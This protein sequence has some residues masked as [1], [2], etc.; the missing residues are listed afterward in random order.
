MTSFR[1]IPLSEL[2][3]ERRESPD[4][5][6][7]LRGDIP[8][9][10]KVT[11]A[12]GRIHLRTENDSS[13]N[14]IL[15]YP[16]DLL[17]SGINAAKGAIA[18]NEYEHLIAA[19]IHYSAYSINR[20][21]VEPRYLWWFL[22]SDAF[23][24]II[25]K[26]IPGGIKSELRAKRLLPLRVPV[27]S[28][29]RQHKLVNAIDLAADCIKSAIYLRATAIQETTALMESTIDDVMNRTRKWLSFD[30]YITFRPRSGPSFRTRPDWSG[31]PVLMPSSVTGFGVNVYKVEYGDGS[32][33][34]SEK[35]HLIPG[36]IL[37]A[38]GNKRD[39]VGN[40]GVVPSNA[41]GWVCANLLMR[42]Q[43]DQKRVLPQFCVYWLRSP[44]IR[45]HVKWVM[46]GTN[47]NIQKINQKKILALPF[48]GDIS[49][50][51]Q[52]KIVSAL[53]A[54]QSTVDHLA[55]IQD[56]SLKELRALLP[57]ILDSTFKGEL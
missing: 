14:L 54:L 17:I 37:I 51:E 26:E 20:V 2:I 1:T 42:L 6:S 56:Q 10:A 48:P 25:R 50:D 44:K 29:S 9:V 15:A 47:P 40:A 38:R 18:L 45:G 4:L 35:D 8:L 27:P 52:R 24:D 28:L 3:E 43:V 23:R 53:D 5:D 12:D 30:H 19:T 13:T 36:D 34:V 32:E 41:E 55:E 33:S 16:G 21:Q 39:Q 7:V 11:F 22:R 31:T 46:G 49:F 57:S